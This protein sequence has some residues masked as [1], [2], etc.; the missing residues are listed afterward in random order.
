MA[1]RVVSVDDSDGRLP[2]SVI[3]PVDNLD[4]V[5][6]VK[7]MLSAPDAIGARNALG[8]TPLTFRNRWYSTDYGP[9][10]TASTIDT[11]MAQIG[12]RVNG[13]WYSV[14]EFGAVG[15]GVTDDTAA[16][17]SAFD[18]AV[19]TLYFPPGV[20]AVSGSGAS[21]LTLTRNINIV[22]CNGRHASIYA[23]AGTNT[24]SIIRVSFSQNWGLGNV[25][26]W[27][28]ANM[29]VQFSNAT[30]LHALHIDG[31]FGI[32]CSQIIGCRLRGQDAN[33]GYAIRV[34]A[35]LYYSKISLCSVTS[36][37]MDS[38]DAN[39]IEKCLFAGAGE[40]VVY[41]VIDGVRNNVVRD[42]CFLMSK[43]ALHVVNGSNIRFQNNQCEQPD[44][45]LSASS[46]KSMVWIEGAARVSTN[47]VLSE[48]NFGGG[49]N[50][51]RL[52]YI[53]NAEQTI[54]EKNH[55]V[56]VGQ[57]PGF[58]GKEIELTA[59]AKYSVIRADNAV[60]T[61]VA[62]P[63]IRTAFKAEVLD[64]GTGTAGVLKA[65]TTANSW[66]GGTYFK[67]DMGTVRFWTTLGG[68]TTAAGTTIGTLPVGFRP[69]GSAL[70]YLPVA[71]SAG[72]G[73]VSVSPTTGEIKVVSLPGDTGLTIPSFACG[74]TTA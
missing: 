44:T 60:L 66:T 1:A 30:G 13:A 3:V 11:A 35:L 6:P 22:G 46:K 52:I 41:D 61:Q 33:G 28:F 68:G 18:N 5:A 70:I 43:D 26:N 40:G 59:N 36:I 25:Y 67:D 14:R 47:I 21:I 50:L 53:D 31:G 15:D 55:F 62:N 51:D 20:Y 57:S 45:G 17:Q 72:A 69:P 64:A 16:I 27:M 56:A 38:Q 23:T 9:T 71:T 58:A 65:L 42:C 29:T 2:S 74:T 24:T 49:T 19:G 63:R 34:N 4:A 7:A 39:T 37:Y 48:N 73:V 10:V 12:K 8:L 32:F 54:I